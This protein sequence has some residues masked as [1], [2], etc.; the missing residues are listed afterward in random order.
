MA[1]REREGGGGDDNEAPEEVTKEE[2]FEAEQQ[3]QASE[4]HA[5]RRR[6]QKA[7]AIRSDTLP[8]EILRAAVSE[9]HH[10]HPPQSTHGEHM[11]RTSGEAGEEDGVELQEE[12]ELAEDD[13]VNEIGYRAGVSRSGA[14]IVR[15]QARGSLESLALPR[16]SAQS[17]ATERL[18]KRRRRERSMLER[19][20]A[21]QPAV[22]FAPASKKQRR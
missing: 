14:Q 6:R 8:D 11:S 22:S 15:S 3:L 20:N 12:S 1:E 10:S 9:Q 18:W 4:H 16:K 19:T 17:F 21:L 13:P 2:A 7:A 5:Q